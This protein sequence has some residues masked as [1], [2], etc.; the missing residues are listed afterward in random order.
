MLHCQSI[1][2]WWTISCS[3]L[4]LSSI[5]LDF[6]HSFWSQLKHASGLMSLSPA[7]HLCCYF[8]TSYWHICCQEHW[9]QYF[10]FFTISDMSVTQ[11]SVLLICIVQD[12]F[13]AFH[14]LCLYFGSSHF[15]STGLHP[16]RLLLYWMLL[17]HSQSVKKNYIFL[18][19]D[20]LTTF[21]HFHQS[22]LPK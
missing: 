18:L 16:L 22:S 4:K 17:L 14:F 5:S 2:V 12:Y 15:F 6:W 19:V 7:Y 13:V 3:F 10:N 11:I 21:L 8:Q 9:W 1:S 20:F